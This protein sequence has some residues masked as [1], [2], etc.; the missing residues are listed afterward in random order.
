MKKIANADF[1]LKQSVLCLGKFDGVHAGHRR[2]LEKVGEICK[3]Q[4][5][6][7]VAFTFQLHPNTLF[8]QGRQKL[9]TTLREKEILLEQSGI[10]TMIIY[11]FTRDTASMLPEEFV[12]NVLVKQCD[13]KAIVVGQDFHFGKNRGGDV[14]LLQELSAIYGYEL[15][16]MEKVCMYD[17][18]VSSTRIRHL[19]MNGNIPMANELLSSPYCFCS[20]VVKGNQIGRTLDM[21][22]ANQNVPEDKLLPPYGVYASTVM[23]RGKMYTSVTNIGE[24]P[25]IEGNSKVGIETNIFA[26][27]P[28]FYGEDI[29]VY[30]HKYI[31][32]EKKFSS[33]EE[34]KEQMQVDMQTAK[35]ISEGFL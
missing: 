34:L 21:P 10:E 14:K 13:V 15:Y 28:M 7:S 18:I 3:N 11:P 35:K 32:P 8:G 33:L 6:H 4:D 30:L 27:L 16:A 25:T 5:Y 23:L 12:E 1:T 2:L 29:S 22:T 26:D 17:E 19:I 24:K 31:R 9:L 20:K